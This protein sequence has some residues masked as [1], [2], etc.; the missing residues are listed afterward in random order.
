MTVRAAIA[1]GALAG[2]SS[3]G[4]RFGEVTVSAGAPIAILS[5]STR[6]VAS[7]AIE[8]GPGCL[9]YLDP[10]SPE[11]IV[12]VAD[13]GTFRASARAL[14]G[15]LAIAVGRDGEMRCDSDSGTGH[16]PSAILEGPGDYSIYVGSLRQPAA[17]PYDLTIAPA[18]E[19]DDPAAGATIS[20]EISVVVSSEPPGA[21]VRTPGGAVL[22]TTP[23]MFALLIPSSEVGTDRKFLLELGGR[24]IVEARAR[25]TGSVVTLHVVLPELPAAS[26]AGV[27]RPARRR[28]RSQVLDPWAPAP[29]AHRSDRAARPR[30]RGSSGVSSPFE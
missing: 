28:L 4:P 2:C 5:G 18:D 10:S 15:R 7:A 25:M 27:A 22:G 3:G 20:I 14:G 17:L 29:T 24:P 13:G 12:H 11:H 16:E 23:A 8:I 6:E 9:G 26:D 19:R 30:R 1:L 21:E